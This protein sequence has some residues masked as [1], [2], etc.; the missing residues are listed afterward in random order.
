MALQMGWSALHIAAHKGF[1]PIV[2]ELLTRG[3]GPTCR[4]RC[5]S[6]CFVGRLGAEYHIVKTNTAPV[7]RALLHL[8][9]AI[10]FRE[11]VSA[12]CSICVANAAAAAQNLLQVMLSTVYSSSDLRHVFSAYASLHNDTPWR[13]TPDHHAPL[14]CEGGAAWVGVSLAPTFPI[15]HWK[16]LP[17]HMATIRCNSHPLNLDG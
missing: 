10:P 6:V 15:W 17:L 16:R 9:P 8:L 2:R 3:Q 14:G 12:G 4:T 1:D 11:R 13:N 7:L 5:A